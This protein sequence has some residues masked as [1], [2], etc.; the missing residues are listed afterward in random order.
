MDAENR[1]PAADT[2]ELLM[3]LYFKPEVGQNVALRAS[4]TIGNSACFNFISVPDIV[5]EVTW[6]T[7]HHPS[8]QLN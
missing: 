6:H 8:T 2:P 4:T 5:P 1:V 7:M 3:C